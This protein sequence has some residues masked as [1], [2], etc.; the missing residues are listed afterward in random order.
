LTVRTGQLIESYLADLWQAAGVLP[1][2][3]RAELVAD[4][5]EHIE[6]SLAEKSSGASPAEADRQVRELLDRLGSPSEIV[7]AATEGRPVDRSGRLRAHEVWAVILLLLGG[8]LWFAGW[9]VGLALLWTSDRWNVRDKLIGTLLLPGGLLGGAFIAGLTFLFAGGAQS[10]SQP[11]AANTPNSL[12]ECSGSDSGSGTVL[13]VMM[14]ALALVP[15]FTTAYLS[16][17]ARKPQPLI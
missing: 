9:I 15:I 13:V 11:L 10:C 6:V 2:D 17:R 16:V 5:R 3:R 14:I 7:A 12:T 1:A 4:V 8:F